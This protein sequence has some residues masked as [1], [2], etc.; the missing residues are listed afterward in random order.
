[1]ST[2][3]FLIV[4]IAFCLALYFTVSFLLGVVKRRKVTWKDFKN[5]L[6]NIIDS[7]FGIG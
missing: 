4:L 7:L 5:W 2:S 6:R 1:M 3:E